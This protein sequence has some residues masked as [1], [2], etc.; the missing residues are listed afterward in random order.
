[1]AQ[2]ATVRFFDE[3][4]SKTFGIIRMGTVLGDD[5]P[6]KTAANIFIENGLAGKPLTPFKQSMYRPMLY[7]DI[8]DIAKAY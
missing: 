1:M 2:E 8:K 4:T 6:V 3:M 5:M 7:V